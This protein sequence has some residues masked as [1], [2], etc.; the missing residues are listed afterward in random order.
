MKQDTPKRPFID[1]AD[2]LQG[3]SDDINFHIANSETY[4][5]ALC[6]IKLYVA[7]MNL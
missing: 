6:T 4:L 2:Y 7:K 1:F 5:R 3:S